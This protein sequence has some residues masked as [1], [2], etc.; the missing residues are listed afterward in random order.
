MAVWLARWPK[1]VHGWA[2]EETDTER[3]WIQQ[4]GAA[5]YACSVTD[6]DRLCPTLRLA[7]ARNATPSDADV[8]QAK[9][10]V[11]R[12]LRTILRDPSYRPRDLWASMCYAPRDLAVLL[13][14]HLKGD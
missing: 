5:A 2:H 4:H 6:K 7:L 9:W 8:E 13:V 12:H 10:D 3:A 11:V 14:K 1:F